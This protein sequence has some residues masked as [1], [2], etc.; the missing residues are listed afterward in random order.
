MAA[1]LVPSRA[2]DVLEAL[3]LAALPTSATASVSGAGGPQ[4]EK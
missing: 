2:R 4:E 3:G 1:L